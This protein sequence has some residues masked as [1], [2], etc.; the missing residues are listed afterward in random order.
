MVFPTGRQV[1]PVVVSSRLRGDA[2]RVAARHDPVAVQNFQAQ[3]ARFGGND[4]FDRVGIGAGGH[5]ERLGHPRHAQVAAQGVAA[6]R[7]VGRLLH[8][9]LALEAQAQRLAGQ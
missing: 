2:A 1:G 7:L 8:F 6:L 3:V 5:V 9:V 4:V